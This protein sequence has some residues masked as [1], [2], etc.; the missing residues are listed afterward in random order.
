MAISGEGMLVTT[1]I[2][3]FGHVGPSY[4]TEDLGSPV[5]PNHNTC[6]VTGDMHAE[7]YSYHDILAFTRDTLY[8]CNALV[9]Q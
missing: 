4:F 1:N 8:L 5:S 2:P 6:V 3:L 9:L 7:E